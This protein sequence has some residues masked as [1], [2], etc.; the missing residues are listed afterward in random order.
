MEY[1]AALKKKK[2]VDSYLLKQGKVYA[3][4]L[5]LKAIYKTVYGVWLHFEIKKETGSIC[6]KLFILIIFGGGIFRCSMYFSVFS[7]YDA[8]NVSILEF[9]K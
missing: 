9:K 7:K 6:S 5:I 8:V 2:S 1:N 4:I 3:I